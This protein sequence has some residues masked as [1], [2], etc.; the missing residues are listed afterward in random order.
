MTYE[1]QVWANGPGGGTPRSAQRLNHQE[2]G[3]LDASQRLDTL[4]PKVT[5]KAPILTPTGVKTA[6]YTPA[7]GELVRVDATSGTIAITLPAAAPGMVV[8]IKKVDSTANT[9]TVTPTGLETIDGLAS[10]TLRLL[11][12]SR[13]LVGVA[14]GWIVQNGLNTLTSL[15]SR[16]AALADVTA[17][18]GPSLVTG[19]YYFTASPSATGTSNALGVGTLRAVPWLVTNPV[20]LV[21]IGAEVSTVGEAGSKVRLG[22]YSDTNGKPGALVLDAGQINGDSATVQEVTIAQTLAP[23]LYWVAAVVQTVTTTQPT[24]RT[25]GTGWAPPVPIWLGLTIPTANLT[26]VAVQMTG[27]TGAL[28]N[29]FVATGATASA[30]RIFVKIA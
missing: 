25:T 14:N 13:T 23:G 5:G 28:P 24:V 12:E 1:I 3:I 19:S 9:V 26:A 22:I 30:P 7:S 20:S 29:P 18:K 11:A 4:E 17:L 10:I 16:Y 6:P 8:A 21:R 27:V 15:D 2:A